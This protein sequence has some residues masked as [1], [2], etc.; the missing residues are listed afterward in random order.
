[1]IDRLAQFAR[2]DEALLIPTAL[3]DALVALFSG[4]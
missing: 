3:V 1:M 2:Q 4:V